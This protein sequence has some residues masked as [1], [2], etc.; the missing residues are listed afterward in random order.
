MLENNHLLQQAAVS[1]S[2]Y[3]SMAAFTAAA[4]MYQS[5]YP[6]MNMHAEHQFDSTG[7]EV[8]RERLNSTVSVTLEGI[9]LWK[10]FHSIGTEMIITKYV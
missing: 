9:D 8:K 3:A 5:F 7:F 2:T 6:T 4:N 10:R 1:S